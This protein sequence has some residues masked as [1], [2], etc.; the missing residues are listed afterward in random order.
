MSEK[1]ISIIMRFIKE[2]YKEMYKTWKDFGGGD[3]YHG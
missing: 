1:E 3:F 2:N